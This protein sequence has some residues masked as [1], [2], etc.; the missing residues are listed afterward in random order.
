MDVEITEFRRTWEACVD[1]EL[2]RPRSHR[3]VRVANGVDAD[4]RRGAGIESGY[5]RRLVGGQHGDL[6]V[7]E[8][9]GPQLVADLAIAIHGGVDV[10]IVTGRVRKESIDRGG[11]RGEGAIGRLDWQVAMPIYGAP[12]TPTS[13][14]D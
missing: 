3:S 2:R 5:R 12:R 9:G 6:N 14:S 8:I 7:R 10:D 4:R 11:F 1:I 13:S